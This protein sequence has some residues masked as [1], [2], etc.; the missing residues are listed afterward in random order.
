MVGQLTFT[1]IQD[2]VDAAAAAS[3]LKENAFVAQICQPLK[4]GVYGYAG[5]SIAFATFRNGIDLDTLAADED[6]VPDEDMR[7]AAFRPRG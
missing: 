3:K 1:N 5:T 2:A 6:G 7:A 4:N